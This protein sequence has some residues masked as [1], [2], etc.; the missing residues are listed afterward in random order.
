MP[1][2]LQSAGRIWRV[3]SFLACVIAA[4]MCIFASVLLWTDMIRRHSFSFDE[5]PLWLGAVV[6]AVVG[7]AAAFIAFRL[8]RGEVAANGVTTLPLWFIRG[9]GLLLLVGVGL[10]AYDRRDPVLAIEGFGM[11]CA[12]ILIGRNLARRKQ[13]QKKNQRYGSRSQ[14]PG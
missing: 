7:S 8:V 14:N 2:Y 3:T 4:A 13:P 5:K 9:F 6:I 11:C 1:D 12:M 10:V